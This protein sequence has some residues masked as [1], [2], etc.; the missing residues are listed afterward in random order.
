MTP[1]LDPFDRLSAARQALAELGVTVADLHDADHVERTPTLGEYL[2][3]VI[4]ASG[5]GANRTYGTYW[6]RMATLWGDRRLDELL[7]SDIEDM[8]NFAAAS[9]R[10]RP[11]NP[12]WPARRRARRRRPRHLQ[13]RHR[14]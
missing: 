10:S 6:T 1:P 2:P 14:R 9:A 5:A 3:M 7:A 12:P 4:A 11:L 13:P 8:K